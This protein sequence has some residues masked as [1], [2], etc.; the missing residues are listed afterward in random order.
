[1][2]DSGLPIL[3]DAQTEAVL[4]N[5]LAQGDTALGSI[6]PILGHLLTNRDHSLF[7]DET[8][9]QVG[10]MISHIAAQLLLAQAE[11]A[12]VE[13]PHNLD[14]A[15]QDALAVELVAIPELTTHCH[16]LAIEWQLATHLEARNTID[17]VVSPLLEALIA[18]DDNTSASLA[19]NFLAAQARFIQQQ[20]RMELPLGELP[21]DLF[22]RV[23]QS[24]QESAGQTVAE[25][26]T[27]ASARLRSSFDESSNR[28]G[29]VAKL[30]T[31]M[32]NGAVAGLALGHAGVAIFL[33]ALAI[34]INQDRDIVAIS[35]NERQIARLAVSLCAAGLKPKEV[36][37]QCVLI[38]GKVTLPE[39]FDGL[40]ADRAVAMLAS[41]GRRAS[42]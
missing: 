9:A 31:G 11:A 20:R 25:P 28:L 37:E 15:A 22:H 36:E 3:A 26:V 24:W 10:G 29:M 17:P 6:A 30:V 1:M 41:S 14:D 33:S 13:Q 23:L 7:S 21:G 39:G 4:R 38:H 40:R 8:V 35:T 27:D 18:S 12:R 5:E 34:G 42:G 19:M 16:A 32:G 2:I